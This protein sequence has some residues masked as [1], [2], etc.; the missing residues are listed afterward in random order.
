M[1]RREEFITFR[2]FSRVRKCRG[3]L[4]S[5]CIYFMM[6]MTLNAQNTQF[7]RFWDERLQRPAG[8]PMFQSEDFKVD[9]SRIDK[10]P[11][12]FIYGSRESLIKLG[13]FLINDPAGKILW[14]SIANNTAHI[15]NQWDFDRSGFTW[16]YL[17][18]FGDQRYV[19]RTPQLDNLSVMYIFTG[20]KV[21]GQFIRAHLLHMADLPMEFWLHSE[22]RNYS[23][24]K[25]LGTLETSLL[26]KSVA[27]TLSAASEVLSAEEKTKIE[28]ALREEGLKSCL[29]WLDKPGVNNF[30]GVISG[31]AYVAA[32]YLNDTEAMNKAQAVMTNYLKT[33]VETDGSYGEGMGYFDYP[34][35]Y[36]LPAVLIMNSEEREK[37]F[38]GSGLKNSASWKVYPYLYASGSGEDPETLVHFG[39]NSYTGP[40]T[41]SVNLILGLIYKDPLATWLIKK[42]KGTYNFVEQLMLYSF[43]HGLPEPKSPEQAGLPLMKVFTSGDCFI[44]STWKDNGIV[45][46][47]WSGDGSRIRWS[48]QRPELGSI[49]MGAYG[50]YM[51]VSPGSA[52]YRSAL[53]GIYDQATRSANTIA[54]DDQN[55]VKKPAVIEFSKAGNMADVIV[56]E[57]KQAYDVPMKNVRRSVI[58]VRDPGYFVMVDK[59]ESEENAHKYSWRIHL[60]VKNGLG[61][62]KTIDK[63]HWHLARTAANLDVYLFSDQKMETKQTKGYLHGPGRDY[64]PGGVFEGKL[65]SSVELEAF[66][67][68]KLK[69][70]TYY[71]V[72]F[73]TKKGI[74]APAVKFSGD[75]IT[76]GKDIISFSDG[77][78][79]IHKTGKSEK[80]KLWE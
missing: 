68:E 69:S 28:T 15:L 50:E 6:V 18:M 42:F 12:G 38:S 25:P 26:C 79:S 61:E 22:L 72:L 8:L 14:D 27:I 73:P 5:I 13:N 20:N 7:P 10:Y 62:F 65:G 36:L 70:M 2:K 41:E 45:L 78:C 37:V 48:H 54:I 80:F 57:L 32:K 30:T 3:I 49:S 47:M 63:N 39:D 75:K 76:V 31:G 53:R 59:I 77:E 67:T 11:K 51:V 55:Q 71:S 17:W 40:T 46:D 35:R 24:E 43:D 1:K 52:S 9:L 34:I 19:Y 4:F 66:N 44:R 64:S 23:K 60:N 33:S 56:N 16:G 21:L 58:F 74:T 29:N